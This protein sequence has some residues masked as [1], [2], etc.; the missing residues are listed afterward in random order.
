[1]VK[2]RSD[3]PAKAEEGQ[4]EAQ[5]S[6]HHMSDERTGLTG[7]EVDPK[8]HSHQQGKQLTCHKVNLH[9]GTHQYTV[10]D[11][12]WLELDQILGYPHGRVHECCACV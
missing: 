7:V 12:C 10:T 5:Q 6:G 3:S 1:M 8:P 9:R 2:Q 11:A 4:V